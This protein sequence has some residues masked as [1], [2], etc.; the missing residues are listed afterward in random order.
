L[1]ENCQTSISQKVRDQGK[2][3]TRHKPFCLAGAYAVPA[4][5]L[6]EFGSVNIST[7]TDLKGVGEEGFDFVFVLFVF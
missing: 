1:V 3:A 7:P 4:G 2:S 5:D 6:G